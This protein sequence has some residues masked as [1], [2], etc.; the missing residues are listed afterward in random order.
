MGCTVAGLLV[1]S[2]V[3]V[4]LRQHLLVDGSDPRQMTLDLL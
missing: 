3:L 4:I 1:G 2:N